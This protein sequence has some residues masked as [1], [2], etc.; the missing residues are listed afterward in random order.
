MK[1]YLPFLIV[2]FVAI[3]TL[4]SGVLLYR[5]K[6]A[7]GV[8]LKNHKAEIGS[9]AHVLGATHPVVT[10]EE[11][12]DFQCP[13][14]GILSEP[15]NQMSRDFPQ[16]RIVFKHF[17]LPMHLHANEAARAAEA[18][19]RQG[20]FWKMHD[21]LYREQAAWSKAAD[22]RALFRQY[23]NTIGCDVAKFDKDMDSEPIAEAIKADQEEGTKL[24][25][26]NTPSI[27]LNGTIV[28]PPS[29]DPIDLRA[30]VESAL[31]GTVATPTPKPEKPQ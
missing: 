17:P 3:A 1:K 14:C 7:V 15:L 8:P 18:A 20:Q 30:A 21:L 31:R 12:G 10:L 5:A 23:A 6:R 2:G 24:G 25:V 9:A 22:V 4:T 27:F 16:L 19:G 26:Q 28:P 13:P 29:L 11:F